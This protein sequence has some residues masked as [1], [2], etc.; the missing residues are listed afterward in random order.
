MDHAHSL[1]LSCIMDVVLNHGSSKNNTLWM[2]DGY[3][4]DNNGGVYFESGKVCRP[5]PPIQLRTPSAIRNHRGAR[6]TSGLTSGLTSS[7]TSVFASLSAMVGSGVARQGPSSAFLR[8]K[9][10]RP[11]SASPIL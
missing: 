8:S 2:W 3:G 4:P 1:G 10:T 5:P 7:F 9:P 6:V 11:Q